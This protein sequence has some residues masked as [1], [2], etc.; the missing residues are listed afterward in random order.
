MWTKPWKMTE[1]FLIGGGLLLAGVLLRKVA[2]PI[3]WSVFAWPVNLIVLI[4]LVAG[5]GVM[6]ALRRRVYAFEW[7]MH[8]SAAVPCLLYAAVLTIVMGLLPQVRSGGIARC[9]PSGPSCLY[10]PG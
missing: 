8:S 3:D 1:G 10:G 5:I 4:L 2:G 6:Y 7:M 9:S